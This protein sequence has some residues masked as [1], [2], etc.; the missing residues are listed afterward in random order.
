MSEIREYTAR[1]ASLGYQ[2]GTTRLQQRVASIFSVLHTQLAEY[3]KSELLPSALFDYKTFRRLIS[4]KKI[5]D[6]RK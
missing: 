1:M 6:R 3:E 5:F 4:E 2:R